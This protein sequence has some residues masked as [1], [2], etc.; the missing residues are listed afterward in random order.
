METPPHAKLPHRVPHVPMRDIH[1][2]GHVERAM[3]GRGLHQQTVVIF[4]FSPLAEQDNDA[5]WM[6]FSI[7]CFRVRLSSST[8]LTSRLVR[9][10]NPPEK[11]L[12]PAE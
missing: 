12:D 2:V 5:L 8:C 7:M 1:E 11:E 6:I 9:E 4:R 3:M 10:L